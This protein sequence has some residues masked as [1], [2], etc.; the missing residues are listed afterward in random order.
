MTFQARHDADQLARQLDTAAG[1]LADLD[2]TTAAAGEL[3]AAGPAPRRSGRLAAGVTVAHL[4]GGGVAVASTAPYYSFV[5]WGAPGRHVRA[6]P[7][8][9]LQLAASQ[10]RI[11]DLYTTHAATVLA[12]VK[13]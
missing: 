12:Q 13:G 10:D 5:H 4:S 6:Q 3:V 9:A 2:A 11:L 1:K 7:W 8:L